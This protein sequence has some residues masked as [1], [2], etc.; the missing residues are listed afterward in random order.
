AQNFIEGKKDTIKNDSNCL[1]VWTDGSTFE[2]GTLN[3]RAS[4][5]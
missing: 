3:A 4:I 5:G 1:Q 2:N